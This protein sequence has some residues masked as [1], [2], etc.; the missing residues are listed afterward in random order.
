MMLD[1][2]WRNTI[3]QKKKE[4]KK[5]VEYILIITQEEE[6]DNI[7]KYKRVDG[8]RASKKAPK[9]KVVSKGRFSH[10]HHEA[11]REA[12]NPSI[13][14]NVGKPIRCLNVKVMK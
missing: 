12:Q 4:G 8:G 1:R 13:G 6:E 3:F 10:R 5:K 11:Q 7:F 9:E 14:H 2:T